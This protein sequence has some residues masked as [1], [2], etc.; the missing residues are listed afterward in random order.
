M[1]E[2]GSWPK[3][4]R[5]IFDDF[6]RVSKAPGQDGIV[7]P[8]EQVPMWL[9]QVSALPEALELA[10]RARKGAEANA[11]TAEEK[12]SR[13][14]QIALALLTITLAVGSYQ[15]TYALKHPPWWFVS[16]VP[17]AIALCCLSLTA[18]EALQIDRVGIYGGPEPENLKDI[19]AADVPKVI[20]RSEVH[21]Q[22]LARWTADHKHTDLMQA[23]AWMTRGLAALLI[24][25]L[26]AG[27]AR[28]LPEN[29]SGA[30]KS[31]SHKHAGTVHKSSSPSMKLSPRPK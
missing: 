29:A 21:G 14:V 12:A 23:R 1:T 3:V 5:R 24:A 17:V 8:A 16:L 26:L 2:D 15:L 13:L 7:A 10:Q 30:R 28:A 19:A 27:I 31:D 25:G 11:A 6:R 22:Q 9:D 18:F 20:L 4:S